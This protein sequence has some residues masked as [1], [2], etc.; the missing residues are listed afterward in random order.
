[1]HTL[2]KPKV[3]SFPE[4]VMPKGIDPKVEAAKALRRL[5]PV[6]IL[7]APLILVLAIF[8]FRSPHLVEA[9]GFVILGIIVY[10][11]SSTS[12][13]GFSFTASSPTRVDP[14]RASCTACSTP[15]TPTITRGPGTGC[16]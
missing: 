1:M 3:G 13:I 9:F 4:L 5:A 10:A 11:P 16:T 12:S 15:P 7:Y 8:S 2:Q 14:S 6:T